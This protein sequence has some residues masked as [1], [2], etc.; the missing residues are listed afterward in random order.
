ML[1][2]AASVLAYSALPSR[3]R[4]HWSFGGPYY[5]PEFTS[6]LLVLVAF[7]LLA[8]GLYVGSRW[9]RAYLDQAEGIDA[10]RL[11]Y[12]A[13]ILLMLIGVVLVQF[14]IIWA[15]LGQPLG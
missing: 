8:V 14:V 1:S 4:I 6:T 15:N 11:L 2:I 5:G 13:C 3:I 12:E 9:L 7:P 10:V